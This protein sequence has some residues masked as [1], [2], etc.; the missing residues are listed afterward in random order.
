MLPNE[1]FNGVKARVVEYDLAFTKLIG[2]VDAAKVRLWIDPTTKLPLGRAMTF[3]FG[4]EE[5]T[6]TATHTKF[7]LD[8]KFD[9]KRF[10][11]GK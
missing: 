6:Y 2:D 3:K 5:K 1:A 4:T 10:D 9:S 11:L 7:V 8:P